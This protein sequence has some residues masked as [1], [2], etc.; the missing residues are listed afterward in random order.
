MAQAER[1]FPPAFCVSCH[2]RIEML[3][4]VPLA[5]VFS[6]AAASGPDCSKATCAK[7]CTCVE[8]KCEDQLEKCLANTHCAALQDCA[9]ACAC[10]DHSCGVGCALKNPLAAAT[11]MPLLQCTK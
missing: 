7:E 5:L 1:K 4:A 9:L 8:S 3:K 10:G 2:L 11:A 6:I